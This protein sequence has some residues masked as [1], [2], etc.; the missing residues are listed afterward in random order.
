MITIMTQCVEK[1]IEEK[2]SG[3]QMNAFWIIIIARLWE[4]V[5]V[6]ITQESLRK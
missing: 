4:K 1:I 5:K 3:F 6:C 2:R